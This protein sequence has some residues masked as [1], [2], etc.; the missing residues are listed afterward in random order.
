M[1][2]LL[3][4]LSF[5]VFLP[6]TARAENVLNFYGIIDIGVQ[7]LST[8]QNVSGVSESQQ[9]FGIANGVQSGSR[10][11]MRGFHDF[12][13]GIESF[14]ILENGFNSGNGAAAQ[15]GRMFGRQST[16]SVRDNK[17]GQ[18]DIGRQVNLATNYF[19]PLDPFGEGFGQANIGA[20]F[21]STNTV[22][23]SNM[24]L[25]QAQ[26][27]D[28]FTVGLGYSFATEMTGLYL[29]NGGCTVASCQAT[30]AGYQ[31]QAGN[32]LRAAT[33]GAKYIRGPLL[34]AAGYD[35]LQGPENLPGGSPKPNPTAWVVGG[36]YNFEVVKVSVAY[37]QSRNGAWAGQPA[38]S[39]AATGGI[40]SDSTLGAGAAFVPGYGSNSYFLG[41]AT[42]AERT[43]MLG[44]IQ[45]MQPVGSTLLSMD[46]APQVI[47]SVGYI[48]NV[49]KRSNLYAYASYASN[50]AMVKSAQSAVVGVGL[51]HQ[52]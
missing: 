27:A 47:Y 35:Q 34:L 33:L 23:Y 39:G 16:L 38:G 32:N 26:P 1:K 7:Y 49:T 22:R 36:L 48:Y 17:I 21:G 44:S 4:I 50:Y 14:F 40:I 24:L 45:V 29:G 3:V 30:N 51:R 5:L 28:G 19:L 37:G 11:G 25:F 6:Q 43:S 12:G 46:T 8:R 52:F 13:G 41:L 10:F 15:G 9:F 2:Q 42:P 20:S 31:F 18:L